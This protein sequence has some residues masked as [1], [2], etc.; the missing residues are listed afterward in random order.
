MVNHEQQQLRKWDQ[1]PKNLEAML[2]EVCQY[3]AKAIARDGEGA[4]CLVEVQVSGA[5]R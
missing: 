2:T 4:T 3:M 5:L 1:K